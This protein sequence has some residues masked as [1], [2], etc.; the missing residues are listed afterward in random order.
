MSARGLGAL[1]PHMPPE[2]E[3]RELLA[4]PPSR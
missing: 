3:Q 1:T 2:L 4:P